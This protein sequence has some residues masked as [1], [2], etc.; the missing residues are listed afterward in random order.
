MFA[1]YQSTRTVLEFKVTAHASNYGLLRGLQAFFGCGRIAIDNR[2]DNTYKF[3]VSSVN[4]IITKVIPHFLAYPLQGSKML[5]FL[6]FE[7]AARMISVG[8]HLTAD[9]QVA[10]TN[11]ISNMNSKRDNVDKYNYL[12]ANLPVIN[13]DYIRGFVDAE[14]HFAVEINNPQVGRSVPTVACS[15]QV[16]QASHD[17][18]LLMAILNFFGGSRI[19]PKYDIYD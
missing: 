8:R 1:V 18:L 13:A 16:A 6:D 5:N 17:A 19:K 12:Q 2:R 7:N 14:G 15:L 9:G 4:D 3:V 10:I 11:A